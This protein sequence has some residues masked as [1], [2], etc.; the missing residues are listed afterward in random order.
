ME[1]QSNHYHPTEP[2]P[3]AAD[4]A[5]VGIVRATRACFVETSVCAMFRRPFA[6]LIREVDDRA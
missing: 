4:L 1:G 2:R 3:D 5:I 6:A